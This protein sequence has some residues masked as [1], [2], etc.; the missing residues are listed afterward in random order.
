MNVI[1]SIAGDS[2]AV[3]S[4][5]CKLVYVEELGVWVQEDLVG[6]VLRGCCEEELMHEEGRAGEE[7][8]CG[9]GFGCKPE[10]Y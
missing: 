1:K 10:G 4:P 9:V 8:S 7:G 2:S 3:R 6:D 5:R